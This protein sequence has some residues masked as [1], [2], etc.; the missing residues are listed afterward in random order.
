MGKTKDKT[1][2][3]NIFNLLKRNYY[4]ISKPGSFSSVGKQKIST[5]LKVKKHVKDKFK[6]WLNKQKTH[7]RFQ[8]PKKAQVYSRIVSPRPNYMWDADLCNMYPFRE[9]NQGHTYIL[10]CLDI[11]SRKMVTEALKT[12]TGKEVAQSFERIFKKSSPSI[13]RTDAGGEFTAGTV[14]QVFKKYKIRHYIAYNNGKASYAERSIRTLKGILTKYMFH[15]KT[16]KWLDILQK[17]THSY[18]ASPHSSIG[19]APNSVNET[20]SKD[21]FNYQYSRVTKRNVKQAL[22]REKL[23]EKEKQYVVGDKVHLS[24]PSAP[25]TKD[26]E[27]KW[28]EEVFVIEK[29]SIR[30]GI[31]V[32]TVKDLQGEEVKGSFYGHELQQAVKDE[33]NTYYDIE[34][35][36]DTRTVNRKKQYLVKFK[37]YPSKFNEWIPAANIK[38]LK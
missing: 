26:N 31:Y 25:F 1:A 34:K 16:Y 29:S 5:N 11:F 2:I 33:S 13:L 38:K 15:K 27:P 35:V 30:D 7:L 3:R 24:K 6:D 28:T 22:K 18:N 8:T 21:I 17:A 23:R 12:K 19:V 9:Y 20:N 4:D 14:Q 32:Y 36:V 37:N 10:V